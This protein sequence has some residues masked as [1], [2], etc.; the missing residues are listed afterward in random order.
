MLP[1]V[2][3]VLGL[4]GLCVPPL[5]C[6]ALPLGLI[7]IVAAM[8][9]PAYGRLPFSIVA[10]VVPT[11]SIPLYALIAVPNFIRFQAR[12]KQGECRMNLRAALTGEKS[13][14]GEF[15]RYDVHPAKI[16]FAPERSNRYLYRL[17]SEGRLGKPGEAGDDLVGIAAD[18]QRYP[19]LVPTQLDRALAQYAGPLGLKGTCPDCSITMACAG[20]IDGDAEVDVWS[21]STAERKDSAG[22]PIPAGELHHDYD[23][24]TDSPNV[25]H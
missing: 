2:A 22:K 5:G 1:I 18:T 19:D 21:V 10:V 12:S 3:L 8:K 11:L 24:V 6:L 17:D 23:D 15:D 7:G 20:N 9:N 14:F 25:D 16:G 13:Y 4:V